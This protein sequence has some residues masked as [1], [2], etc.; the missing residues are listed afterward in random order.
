MSNDATTSQRLPLLGVIL[1]AAA[2][3]AALLFWPALRPLPGT[4]PPHADQQPGYQ[5]YRKYCARCHGLGGHSERA[6]RVAKHRVS[7]VSPEWK[8]RAQADSIR[9]AIVDGIGHMK[10]MG[11]D[12]TPELVDVLV[13][14]VLWMPEQTME[15]SP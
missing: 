13:D 6:A 5:P 2:L 7:L 15:E 10:G 12:L 14:F 9:V 1:G 11:S 3:G 4:P 8:A